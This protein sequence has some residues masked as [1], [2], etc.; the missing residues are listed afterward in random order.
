MR[1]CDGSDSVRRN[2]STLKADANVALGPAMFGQRCDPARHD[3]ELLAKRFQRRRDRRI[4]VTRVGA[5]GTVSGLF[6][7]VRRRGNFIGIEHRGR[8]AQPMRESSDFLEAA[9]G[10]LL[11]AS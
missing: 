7:C 4:E 9:G 3:R 11:R 5:Q 8:A 2:N 6:K 1:F 10:V